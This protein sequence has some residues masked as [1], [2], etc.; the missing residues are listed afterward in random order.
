MKRPQL[1]VEAR[2][3]L[4]KQVKKLRREGFLPANIY[5]KD[6]ASTA[7]QV[8]MTEFDTVYKEV[9]ETGLVDVML[10]GERRPVLIKNLQMN[11][12]THTPLH[13][14]FYQVNLKEKV[15]TMVPLEIVGEPQAVSDKLGMLLTPVSEV[16][17]EALPEALPDKIEVDVAR[18]AAVG[19]QLMLSDVK[20]PEGVTLLDDESLIIAQIGELAVEEPEPAEEEAALPEVIGEEGKE[21]AEGEEAPAE[22]SPKKDE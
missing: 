16:E 6:L 18:L 19:D 1:P 2:T 8:P 20:A 5:G 14:D 9:G 15:K 21:A 17:V 22:E 10:N 3:T 7:V 13:A 12:R 11:F 4:G